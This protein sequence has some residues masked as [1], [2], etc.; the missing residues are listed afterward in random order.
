[1][2]DLTFLRNWV[3]SENGNYCCLKRDSEHSFLLKNYAWTLFLGN[4]FDG[5]P[6]DIKQFDSPEAILAEGWL[7]D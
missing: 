6:D 1:M 5:M 3:N 7:V 4:I 2:D